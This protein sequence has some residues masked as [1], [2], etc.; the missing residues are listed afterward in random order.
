MHGLY[1][2]T[3]AAGLR[4]EKISMKTYCGEIGRKL[5]HPEHG[6]GLAER[7]GLLLQDEVGPLDGVHCRVLVRAIERRE[8]R[9]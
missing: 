8:V 1:N 9:R 6:A 3:S 2:L 7:L 4:L 5:G